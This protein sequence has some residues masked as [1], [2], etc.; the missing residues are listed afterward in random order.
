MKWQKIISTILHPIVL[1]TIG[2]LLYLL[3]IDVNINRQ[4]QLIIFSIIFVATYIIPLLL[5][6]FLKGF[7]VITSFQLSTI[8]ERK[9]PLFLMTALFFSLGKMFMALPLVR[10]LGLLFYGTT[11]SLI[12]VYFLF[13]FKIKSSLHILS[14]AS[15]ISFF[16]LIDLFNHRIVLFSLI[17]VLFVLTGILAKA[18]LDLKAH[19][20]QEVYIGFCI[21]F[22][23]PLISF[24]FL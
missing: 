16:L 9:I 21:G 20:A 11:I 13:L 24:T 1:P 18:R 7:G 10:E 14:L 22:L 3:L 8:K 4:Q 6:L 2:L 5:L 12:L 17:S 23:G 19:T 15:T